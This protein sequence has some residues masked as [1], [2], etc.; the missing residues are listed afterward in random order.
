MRD[1]E[2]LKRT[3]DGLLQKTQDAKV[4]ANLEQRQVG[5]QFRIIDP[6]RR[7][8]RP[9]SPDRLRMNFIG[10][11]SGLGLGLVIA[12]LLEYRDTSLRTEDDVLVALALPVVALVPTLWTEI[13][14]NTARRRR[15]MLLASSLGITLVVSAAAL[16]W[17]LRLFERWGF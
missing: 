14:I 13:E 8:E 4:S 7:P 2:M 15:H 11:L 5:E 12:A 17:K 10:A 3:Y 9:R 1:Y 6:A 16:V